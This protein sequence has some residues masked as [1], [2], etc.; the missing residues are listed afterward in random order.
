[1]DGELEGSCGEPGEEQSFKGI[2]SEGGGDSVFFMMEL[3]LWQ[4]GYFCGIDVTSRLIYGHIVA[5]LRIC[6]TSVHKNL[7]FNA[8]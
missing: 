1:M 4:R 5:A 7:L 8:K 2:Q 6:V 3:S